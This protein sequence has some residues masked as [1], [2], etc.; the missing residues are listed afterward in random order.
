M[1]RRPSRLNRSKPM[2][3]LPIYGNKT[4]RV[5]FEFGLVLSEVAKEKGVELTPEISERAER[6]FIE[7]LKINGLTKTAL[8]FV[9]L[10]L[11]SFE[12]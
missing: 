10:V 3:R 9:P 8:N 12:A 7:E 5:A 2:L 4:L 6:I 11:A 1:K